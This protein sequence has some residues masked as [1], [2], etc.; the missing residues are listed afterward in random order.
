MLYL[1]GLMLLFFVIIDRQ[2]SVV[3]WKCYQMDM[4]VSKNAPRH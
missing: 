3:I 1:S 4:A 2:H